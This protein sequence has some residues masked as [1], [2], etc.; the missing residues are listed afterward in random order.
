MNLSQARVAVS[1][2]NDAQARLRGEGPGTV[3]APENCE[4]VRSLTGFDF[5]PSELGECPIVVVWVTANNE[6]NFVVV[7]FDRRLIEWTDID[8]GRLS[9]I[10]F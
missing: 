5:D 8:S 10:D 3:V 6:G 9:Q 2:M 4:G 7:D 1:A